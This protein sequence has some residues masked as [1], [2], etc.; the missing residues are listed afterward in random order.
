MTNFSL[1]AQNLADPIASIDVLL[2]PVQGLGTSDF[3][4]PEVAEEGEVFAVVAGYLADFEQRNDLLRVL[5]G[6]WVRESAGDQHR[7][8]EDLSDR[9][10]DRAAR[11]ALEALY[12]GPDVHREVLEYGMVPNTGYYQMQVITFADARILFWSALLR[13]G[14]DEHALEDLIDEG[15]LHEVRPL[16]VEIWNPV[17]EAEMVARARRRLGLLHALL[18]PDR[19]LGVTVAAFT[20]V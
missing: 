17:D 11:F 12:I 16:V 10:R 14:A 18:P 13:G 3:A 6:F 2:Y 15:C 1:P 8:Y 4:T 7:F 9:A 20:R 19:K 5:E